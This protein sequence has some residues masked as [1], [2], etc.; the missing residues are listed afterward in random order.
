MSK[1]DITEE[2]RTKDKHLV[3]IGMVLLLVSWLYIS[4]VAI[5]SFITRPRAAIGIFSHQKQGKWLLYAVLLALP[6]LV[7]RIVTSL[8]Y[9]TTGNQAL[10]PVSGDIGYKVGLGL[11]EELIMT[12]GFVIAG[13]ATRNIGTGDIA[14]NVGPEENGLR[15]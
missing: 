14:T 8:V 1:T 9:F 12:I 5:A 2:K 7:I 13:I 10:N 3:T 15:K 4:L 6:L 11:I